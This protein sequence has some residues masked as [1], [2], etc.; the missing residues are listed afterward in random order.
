MQLIMEHAYANEDKVTGIYLLATL[1]EHRVMTEFKHSN[2][3][4]CPK[5]YPKIVLFLFETYMHKG[6]VEGF[7]TTQKE[8]THRLGEAE[9]KITNL[10]KSVDY[11]VSRVTKVETKKVNPGNQKDPKDT[12]TPKDKDNGK[13]DK[14]E[15]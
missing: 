6:K 2:F 7:L 3:Y 14:K 12:K 10:Q 15:D 11:L 13:G 1:Q 8:L 5:V 4:Q 9:T